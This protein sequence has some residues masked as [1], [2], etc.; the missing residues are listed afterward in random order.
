MRLKRDSDFSDSTEGI[1]AA[2]PAGRLCFLLIYVSAYQSALS[3]AQSGQSCPALVQHHC[4]VERSYGGAARWE[5]GITGRKDTRPGWSLLAT[6]HPHL[7]DTVTAWHCHNQLHS[8]WVFHYLV[9][10]KTVGIFWVVALKGCWWLGTS[11]AL[12]C[13]CGCKPA[14][15]SVC[16]LTRADRGHR[17][18]ASASEPSN[19]QSAVSAWSRLVKNKDEDVHQ[20]LT[21]TSWLTGYKLR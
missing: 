14:A 12:L 18:D 8:G 10:G 11:S 3:S 15:R 17:A 7:P 13:W 16:G 5:R 1:T 19:Q 20:L 21:R 6:R 9:A 2:P 4:S